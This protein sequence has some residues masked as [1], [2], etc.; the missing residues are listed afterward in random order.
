M[1]VTR[2]REGNEHSDEPGIISCPMEV[3][4]IDK[5]VKHSLSQRVTFYS[6]QVKPRHP[7]SLEQSEISKELIFHSFYSEWSLIYRSFQSNFVY[8]M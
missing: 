4:R 2:V 1:T 7:F 5:R 8:Q 6:F 3:E